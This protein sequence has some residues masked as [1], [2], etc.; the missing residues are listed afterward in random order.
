MY[1]ISGNPEPLVFHA[2]QVFSDCLQQRISSGNKKK[3]LPNFTTGFV[4]K[5][6]LP[7][8]TF[9]KYTWHITN[10]LHVKH[11]FDTPEVWLLLNKTFCIWKCSM[12]SWLCKVSGPMVRHNCHEMTI[13]T[14]LSLVVSFLLWVLQDCFVG[15]R[16]RYKSLE[17]LWRTEMEHLTRTRCPTWR[18][19]PS[20]T[21]SKNKLQS[22]RL[23][24]RPTS[25]LVRKIFSKN[26]SLKLNLLL[27]VYFVDY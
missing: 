23:N 18:T 24:W 27:N 7:L 22:D 9:T 25:K 16:C 8:G 1:K 12:I 13:S 19:F 2:P 15:F 3:R 11:I 6:A 17:V 21:F 5:D 14:Q 4:R 10:V 20:M 26:T